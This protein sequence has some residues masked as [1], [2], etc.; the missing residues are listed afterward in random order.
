MMHNKMHTNYPWGSSKVL[1]TFKLKSVSSSIEDDGTQIQSRDDTNGEKNSQNVHKPPPAQKCVT[2][3]GT[4][5][6]QVVTASKVVVSHDAGISFSTTSGSITAVFTMHN[7]CV[8][9]HYSL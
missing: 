9:Y 1:I 5:R 7:C 6:E 3:S 2:F 4:F 8:Y